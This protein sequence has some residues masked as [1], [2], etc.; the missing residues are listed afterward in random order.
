MQTCPTCANQEAD[1]HEQDRTSN[2][3]PVHHPARPARR[4]GCPVMDRYEHT[5]EE[6]DAL[7]LYHQLVNLSPP[8]GDRALLVTLRLPNGRYVG[9][10]WLSRQD[11][12]DLTDAS[13]GLAAVREVKDA[14]LPEVDGAEVAE[15]LAALENLA[16]RGEQK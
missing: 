14:G 10:I 8:N 15:A 2:T 13:V 7:E 5:P 4:G 12:H 1:P 6:L 9:D 11:V 16:N 3:H